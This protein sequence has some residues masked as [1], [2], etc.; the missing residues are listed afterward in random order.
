MVARSGEEYEPCRSGQLCL[1]AATQPSGERR[2][3]AVFGD[4]IRA[5]PT[6]S[7]SRHVREP[8]LS[9]ETLAVE[10]PVLQITAVLQRAMK[11]QRVKGVP[12]DVL[13]L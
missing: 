2:R 11:G 5:A 10:D 1:V 13:A 9:T 12:S 6:C 8:P 4:L 3:G 7:A